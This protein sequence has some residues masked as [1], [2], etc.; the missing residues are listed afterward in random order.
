MTAINAKQITKEAPHP[1]AT[2][3]DTAP[4]RRLFTLAA[5]AERHSGFLTLPS[6][7][8]QVHKAKP[9]HSSKGIVPGNGLAPAV[10]RIAGRVLI[11]EDAYFA[12]VD[13]QQQDHK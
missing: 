1:S 5:F 12:W 10:V 7:T 4:P 11:D 2:I 13:S 8:N 9:R 6:I 3:P